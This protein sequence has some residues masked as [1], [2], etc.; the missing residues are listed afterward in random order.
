[1][2]VQQQAVRLAASMVD[3]LAVAMVAST[4]V[5][6]AHRIRA[7]QS[8]V[9]WAVSL[10]EAMVERLVDSLVGEMVVYLVG[11]LAGY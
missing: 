6:T 7:F 3:H 9:S 4:A 2:L 10:A 1:M 5:P 8:V 11:W